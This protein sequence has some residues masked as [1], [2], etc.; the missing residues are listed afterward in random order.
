VP[1]PSF[2][3]YIDC[4]DNAGE[5]SRA[6]HWT[7]PTLSS[8]DYY[9]GCSSQIWSSVP[10]NSYGFESAHAGNGYIG[11]YTFSSTG[12]DYREYIQSELTAALIHDKKYLVQFYVNLA[13]SVAY[14]CNDIGIYFSAQ[15]LDYP[16]LE[17][18]LPY[19]P[20]IRNDTSNI[21]ATQNG[22][23]LISD[24]LTALGGEKYLCIGNF[25][26]DT[27]SSNLYIGSGSFWSNIGY[28]YIDDISV[29]LLDEPSGIKEEADIFFQL[30]P[31]PTSDFIN[32]K[33]SIPYKELL[34]VDSFGEVVRHTIESEYVANQSVN[35]SMLPSGVYVILIKS[36]SSSFTRKFIV[37]R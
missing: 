4:P 18:T 30:T 24:T 7:T 5:I 16:S 17:H 20:Q 10:N 21:L 28:Y 27:T 37:N 32:V 1:N 9:N 3:E 34:I 8:P 31:N 23:I 2:E 6:L 11:I 25:N 13:D 35:V 26:P 19:H 22:W 14:A 29:S 33:C 15:Q 12:G 36:T